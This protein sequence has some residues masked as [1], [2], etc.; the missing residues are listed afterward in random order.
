V[1]PRARLTLT[2]C[3]AV[4][5][6]LVAPWGGQATA[7]APAGLSGPDIASYQHPSG[8]AIDW[9]AVRNSGQRW[10]F[11]KATEGTTYTNPYFASDWRQSSAAGLYRGAYHYARPSAAAGSASAQA[12]AFANTIGPQQVAGTLPPILDLE[13]SG[14][15]SPAALVGWTHDFLT[16]LQSA[17]GRTPMIY[18]YPS[19]WRNAMGSSADFT[20]Y[21]LWIASYGTS[22]P[23]T[24]GWPHWTF[25]Q[26]TS[27]GTVD[28]IQTPGGT[29]I[30]VFNGTSLDLAALASA[31]T[32]GP[33]TSTAS[34][35]G[36][37]AAVSRPPVN[38][39]YVALPAQRVVDTRSGQGGT[40]GPV[41]GTMTVQLPDTVPADATG[42]VLDVSA[43][44]PKGTGWLRIA[45]SGQTPTTTALNY[46]AG[47]GV[48][49]LVVTAADAQRRVDVSTNAGATDLTVDLVGYY[50]AAQGTGGH[51]SPTQ[52][53]RVVDTR[54]GSGAPSGRVSSSI[55]FTLP[56]SVPRDA[57][58]LALDVT[59]VDPSGDGYL[60]LAP[61]G[62][63]PTTTALNFHG[64]GSTTGL[65][66]TTA[67]NGQVTVTVAGTPTNLV[68]DLVG[69]YEG[70]ASSGSQ[71]V[72][73]SPQRFLDT[74]GGLG[75]KGPGTGPLTLTVPGVV[76]SDA[77]A[78]LLDVS[79]VHPDGR[80]FVRLTA[81]GTPATTTAVNMVANQAR[82]GLVVSGL[83][84]GQITLA[85]YGANTDLVIDLIGYQTSVSGGSSPSPTPTA[86]PSAT[87]TPAP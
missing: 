60:R 85:V 45:P 5:A 15:L 47:Q 23:P 87:T 57:S 20:A 80:G 19:F 9:A 56:D 83:R 11:V 62:S 51:W 76:P 84:D 8:A 17:T 30:S 29:D 55:T 28:G 64:D 31:G 65:A 27:T 6:A 75:A 14:G 10:V 3:A 22:S 2:V 43:V 58:G 38:S 41:S 48:T 44:E 32:W 66:M 70:S 33:A 21:P 34:D 49:G 53:V 1:R 35:S 36:S 73:V 61:A 63:A 59:A 77:T 86:S 72:A 42:V 13:E 78:V 26:Y 82:T 67:T 79:V 7:A 81:P 50:T 68:V 46:T 18:T 24:L 69:Y 4:L 12:Q 40:S 37:G 25:W 74:R 52:P 16:A 39:R 54:S 71:Y